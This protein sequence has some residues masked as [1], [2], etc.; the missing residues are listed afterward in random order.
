MLAC[1]AAVVPAAPADAYRLQ[2]HRWHS[3]T[4]TYHDATRGAYR[5]EIKA[6]ARAWN[7]S[8][9][10]VRLRPA[11]R[12]TA[13][14]RIL[15]DRRLAPAGQALYPVF[16][17]VVSQATIRLRHDLADNFQSPVAAR[18]GIVAVIAHELGHVL[19]LDHENRRCA[20]M[21]SSLWG[22]CER[23][24]EQWR[25]RC[26]AL[27]ADDVRG[28]IRR[29]GGRVRSRGAEF[30]DAE[31]APGVPIGLTA[32]TV[33]TAF[34]T[35]R[36][37]WQMPSGSVARARVLRREGTCPTGPDDPAA[38]LVTEIVSGP[39]RA[40][41]VDDSVSPGR[42]CYA[43]VALGRLG[44]PGALA[45]VTHAYLGDPPVAQF[46]WFAD[47]AGGVV[48]DDVSIDRDGRVVTWRWDFG[49]GTS[50][51]E[52]QPTHIYPAPG[53]YSVTLTVTDDSGQSG[54]S[55]QV[56]RVS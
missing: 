50:S 21:N 36:L 54:A 52:A 24:S 6:A 48:F 56:V 15:V 53:D 12:G 51:A 30:C 43:V 40:H 45:V 39:G 13:R 7:R 26:R 41:T 49:D 18:A 42:Y 37:S 29:F 55:T 44:R 5:M 35:V 4:L 27:E 14:V 10:R 1:V 19:G 8:G 47:G 3:R 9:A 2:S 16:R 20:T 28:L 23:P 33:D 22:R 11:S 17:G 32:A 46:R 31:A 25:Y 34:G 38:Q